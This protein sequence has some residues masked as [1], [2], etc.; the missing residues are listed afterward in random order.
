MTVWSR[1]KVFHFFWALNFLAVHF[2]SENLVT[3]H[4]PSH[5]PRGH[6]RWLGKTIII[7]YIEITHLLLCARLLPRR[8]SRCLCLDLNRL[9]HKCGQ[10]IAALGGNLL[11]ALPPG[12]AVGHRLPKAAQPSG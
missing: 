5:T 6:V 3:V 8:E 12:T 1:N 9:S 11:N 4:S 10:A 7:K 2:M